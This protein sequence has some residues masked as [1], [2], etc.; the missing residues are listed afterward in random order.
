MV[1]LASRLPPNVRFEPADAEALPFAD[2]SFDAVT[3]GF[4][5]GHLARPAVAV[6]EARRV[7]PVGGRV[8][9]SWWMS[10]EHCVAFEIM[11]ES[12]RT[13]GRADVPL[14]PA[15]P[16]E[17]FAEKDLLRELLAEAGFDAIEIREVPMTWRI[18]SAAEL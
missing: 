11:K 5:L 1:A 3:M 9:L 17:L 12:I 15:P 18:G 6:R 8:A 16:F 4:L 13:G 10:P 7:L 2:S 14:P